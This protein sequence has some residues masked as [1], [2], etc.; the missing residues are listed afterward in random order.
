MNYKNPELVIKD[1]IATQTFSTYKELENI[2]LGKCYTIYWNDNYIILLTVNDGIDNSR[3][4]GPHISRFDTRTE[5]C[6]FHT[7]SSVCFA[8]RVWRESTDDERDWLIN[9]IIAGKLI[10]YNSFNNLETIIEKINKEV[11]G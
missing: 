10:N 7:E 11:F 5:H 4:L 2:K 3:K 9:C 8:S 6:T 1:S